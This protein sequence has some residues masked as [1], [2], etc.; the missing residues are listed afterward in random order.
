MAQNVGPILEMVTEK[1]LVRASKE[2]RARKEAIDIYSQI[3][4]ALE[5]G[6]IRRVASLTT[7]NFTGPLQTIIP[8]CT[9]RFTDRMIEQCREHWKDQFWGFLMLGGMSGGGMGF[10]FDP[11]VQEQARDW[12]LQ[13][14]VSTKRAMESQLPFAMDP[15]VYQFSIHEE[16]SW[17]KLLSGDEAIMPDGYYA[18][19]APKWIRKEIR[20][21]TPQVQQELVRLNHLCRM[22]S[23][24]ARWLLDRLLPQGDQ[25]GKSSGELRE[26]LNLHGFDKELHEQIR[27]DLLGGR[28]GLS[29]NRLPP[30][31]IIEDV[32]RD[33]I[34]DLRDMKLV[35]SSSFRSSDGSPGLRQSS[36]AKLP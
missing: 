14:L 22:E 32:T 20:D 1:Y 16:G 25:G 36:I 21:L 13:T 7:Q 30:Q 9:N 3:V 17:A 8:W 15:V 4:T 31:S 29:E 24:K 19:V 10:F 27:N 23:D 35:S 11:A 18:I 2:W 26:R 28:I 6:D 5:E 34:V 12:L 33:D